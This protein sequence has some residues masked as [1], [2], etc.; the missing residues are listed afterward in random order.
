MESSPPAGET[1]AA[2][3]GAA[4]D[5]PKKKESWSDILR[6][7]FF[8]F[9]FAVIMRAFIAAPFSIPSGS[10]LPRLMVGDY[11]FVAKWPYG[12]SRYSMPFGLANF[13]GRI[14]GG[15]PARGDVVVF[16]Y[17][18]G[19][20]EDWV[21]RV[22]GL[23]GDV[24]EVRGGEVILNGR[25]IQRTRIGD[26]LMP[27]SANSPCRRV[28]SEAREVTGEDGTRLCAY[29][30]YRETLPEGRSYDV[31]DQNPVGPNDDTPPVRVPEGHV[32]VMGD[33]RDDSEDSR[34]P[35]EEGGV[36]MLPIDNLLGRVLVTF[37]STDGSA[38][39]LKPWTWFTAA[40]WSRIGSTS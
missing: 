12:Y 4:A 7:L 16:H 29:A 28:G 40:R 33:N 15:V 19:G 21:K 39:W 23:P 27:I 13:G 31:L 38:E 36:G 5:P 30:R 24:V 8:V 6:F 10:M 26:Y 17:P 3:D 9:L 18:G 34:V 11:L 1:P 20:N 2:A 32:F 14:M 37:F 35:L 22:I 25:P